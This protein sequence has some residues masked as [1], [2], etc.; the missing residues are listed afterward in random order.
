MGI[1]TNIYPGWILWTYN[2]R[3][4]KYLKFIRVYYIVSISLSPN[5]FLFED[6]VQ[7]HCL[8]A[9]NKISKENVNMAYNIR[10]WVSGGYIFCCFKFIFFLCD[11]TFVAMGKFFGLGSQPWYCFASFQV[12]MAFCTQW[13][14]WSLFSYKDITLFRPL[15][16]ECRSIAKADTKPK[17]PNSL[18]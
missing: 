15:L 5:F 10:V 8:S 2:Q 16:L 6:T 12:K 18:N 1:E 11:V 3:L 17:E 9:N 7:V 4:S 14:W 13:W